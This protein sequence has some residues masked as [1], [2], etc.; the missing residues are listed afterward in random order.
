MFSLQKEIKMKS[1][2]HYFAIGL[3]A[4]G[5]TACSSDNS[6]FS[7]QNVGTVIGGV[8]GAVA[9]AQFGKGKGQLLGVAAGTMIGGL[10]GNEIGASLDR[11]DKA[12]VM[13]ASKQAQ[14]API[15]ETVTWNNPESGNRGSITPV[16]D[17]RD[18]SGNYCREYQTTI[19]VGGEA[20]NA[21]GTACRQQDGSWKVI[22]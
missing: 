12:Y 5:L 16:R 3:L 13:Q 1:F 18:T 6:M 15:G 20:Q 4:M 10:I 11:A 8:G 17:G 19:I 2:I 22:N 7:K 14:S 9:G 21:Y